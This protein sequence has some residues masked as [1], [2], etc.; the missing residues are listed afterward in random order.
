MDAIE[1]SGRFVGDDY[2]PFLIAEV[3]ANHNGS[4]QMAIDTIAKAA[5]MGADAVKIQSYTP[6]TITI[7][8]D[9]PDFK[10]KSGIWKGKTLYQLYEE[11]H[12]P[13]EWHQDLFD[14]ANKNN[15]IL[16]STPFDESATDLLA[17][18]NSPAYKIA[19]FEAIDIPL[20]RYVMTKNR[21]MF[22]STG[23]TNLA[24]IEQICNVMNDVPELPWVLLHCTSGYPTPVV[25]ANVSTM[26]DMRQRFGVRVGL[27][28]HTI[29][30]EV[31]IAATVLGAAVIEKHF[32]IDRAMGGPDASFSM[33]PQEWKILCEQCRTAWEA[34]G[35]VTYERQAS[36]QQN[37]KF[38]RSIYVVNPIK[39][40]DL[41]TKENIRSIRPGY[42]L[43]PIHMPDVLGAV[44]LQDL[45]FGTAL[46]WEHVQ[47]QS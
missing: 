37:L 47:K 15:I 1:I 8:S 7:N 32:I 17:S 21:P 22:I 29:G 36:E 34:I 45:P 25:E 4:M 27:S 38:R 39:K 33:E 28:D 30:S 13:F 41:F 35:K 43:E 3:S 2:P 10:I 9:L 14:F 26:V 11:A 42:G 44:A 24:E 16:F 20:I 46:K 31:A 19:S 6:D 18:F 12:T 40:G 23:L 5:E